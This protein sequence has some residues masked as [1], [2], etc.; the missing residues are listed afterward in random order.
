MKL[1]DLDNDSFFKRDYDESIIIND[2]KKYNN[3]R[4]KIY[5]SNWINL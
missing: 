2:I 4:Y 1:L 3:R 5:K